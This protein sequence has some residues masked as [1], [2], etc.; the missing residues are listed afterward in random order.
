MRNV[1]YPEER[2]DAAFMGAPG[3]SGR[4]YWKIKYITF[5]DLALNFYLVFERNHVK[6]LSWSLWGFCYWV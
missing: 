2:I 4:G 5:I 1:F 6:L 3:L